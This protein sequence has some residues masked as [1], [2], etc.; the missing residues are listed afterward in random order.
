MHFERDKLLKAYCKR[1]QGNVDFFDVLRVAVQRGS[2]RTVGW[3][4]IE[5]FEFSSFRP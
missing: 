2:I 1:E 5:T 4:S 3:T